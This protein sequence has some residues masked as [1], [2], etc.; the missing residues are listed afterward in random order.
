M[1][2][3]GR[4]PVRPRG[5]LAEWVHPFREEL[6]RQGF[7]ARTAQDNAYVLA[8]LSRWLQREGR[9]P[10][11][12]GAEGIAAFAAARVD[13]GYRRWRTAASLRLM[14]AFLRGRGLLPAAQP[15]RPGPAD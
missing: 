7:T 4:Y 13:G 2:T 8:H 10:A 1:V 12:F 11:E 3:Q 6:I 5:P 15:P 9:D 14:L